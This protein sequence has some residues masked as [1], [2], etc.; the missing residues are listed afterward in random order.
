MSYGNKIFKRDMKDFILYVQNQGYKYVAIHS[1]PGYIFLRPKPS[2]FEH[3]FYTT[4]RHAKE[5]NLDIE[6]CVIENCEECRAIYNDERIW[7]KIS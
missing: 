3:L 1:P 5:V 7:R 4:I 6:P 2:G